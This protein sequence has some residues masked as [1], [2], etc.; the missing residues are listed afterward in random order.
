MGM[1]GHR[2]ITASA[3]SVPTEGSSIDPFS[4]MVATI[5]QVDIII[6]NMQEC[7]LDLVADQ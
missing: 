5:N 2:L 3:R 6:V 4:T 1:V 7:R